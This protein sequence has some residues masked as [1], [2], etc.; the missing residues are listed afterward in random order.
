M[1]V[2]QLPREIHSPE[3]LESVKYEIEQ[4]LAWY[5]EAKV[6]QKV[7]IHPETEPT[8]STETAK[9]IEAWFA[10]HKPSIG[11]LEELIEYLHGLKLP[12]VHVTLAAL[13]N[14]AQRAQLVDWFRGL[15]GTNMML[16]FVADR[17]IGGGIVVR[18]PNHMFDY[19]WR[20]RLV[21]GRTKMAEIITRV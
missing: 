4:Y 21:E 19:S 17:N 15:G 18:T 16:S 6:H 12:V 5:R 7:G 8:Y 20:Q 1:S 13:P 2:F 14:H 3:L 11:A 9:V 10:A